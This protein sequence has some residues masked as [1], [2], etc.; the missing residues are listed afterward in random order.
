MLHVG[1]VAEPNRH[2]GVLY[3]PCISVQLRPLRVSLSEPLC[4]RLLAL[5]R[6]LHLLRDCLRGTLL[7]GQ[8]HDATRPRGGVRQG[9]RVAGVQTTSAVHQ[10]V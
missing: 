6:S 7:E 1:C 5:V 8:G 3:C 2:R 4:W 10:Q 9:T